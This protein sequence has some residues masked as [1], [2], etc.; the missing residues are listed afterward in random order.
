MVTSEKKG[1]E[2][3]TGASVKTAVAASL[4]QPWLVVGILTLLGFLAIVAPVLA[5]GRPLTAALS[6]SNEIP[7]GDPDGSGNTW[8]TLNQGR[9]RICFALDV[10]NVMLPATGAHIHEGAAGEN[11]PVVVSLT[12]PDATGHADGC[13]NGLSKW[14]VKAIRQHPSDY[15]VN[16]HT[17]DFPGG[18]IRGQLSK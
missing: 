5:G 17:T 18:A 1:G 13:V 2:T 12:P 6:G 11:G 7:S 3:M 16:V 9:G 10:T 4:R 14:L 8:L 15:Y